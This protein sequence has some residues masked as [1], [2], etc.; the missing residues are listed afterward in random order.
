MK[1]IILA[2]TLSIVLHFI[3]LNNFKKEEIST[4]KEK[5]EKINKNEVTFVKLKKDEIKDIKKTKKTREIKDVKKT[6]IKE[7]IYNDIKI[8][9]RNERIKKVEKKSLQDILLSEQIVDNS[10]SIQNKTLEK[11]LSQENDIIDEKTLSMIDRLYGK[12]FE[13][14]TKIQKTFIKKRLKNFYE[15]TQATLNRMGYP[16]LAAK[17]RLS[18]INVVE[19]ILY[20]DGS[21]KNLKISSSSGYSVLDEYTL[22]LIR[23]AYKDYPRPKTPTKLK[24]YVNY[25]IY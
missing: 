10:N 24:F 1:I 20:E 6:K 12:E 2:F 9:N 25:E 4:Q 19:F 13:T 15:I 14:Y 7:K 3:V 21:I 16:R 17:M 11:Y 18:G 23:I 22:E 8:E 5:S